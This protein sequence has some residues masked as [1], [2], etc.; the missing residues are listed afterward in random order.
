MIRDI[1]ECITV[2]LG[3]GGCGVRPGAHFAVEDPVAQCLD[4]IDF[5]R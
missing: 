1:I 4:R 2:T 5:G 3:L